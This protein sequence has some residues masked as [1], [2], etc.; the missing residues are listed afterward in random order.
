L[1]TAL[2]RRPLNSV[3]QLGQMD[4][5]SFFGFASADHLGMDT[6]AETGRIPFEF[7][8][9]LMSGV[10]SQ[11]HARQDYCLEERSISHDASLV[12]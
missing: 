4:D 10:V 5:A 6:V 12:I 8:V 7:A 1:Q 9:K 11:I 3:E 2:Q